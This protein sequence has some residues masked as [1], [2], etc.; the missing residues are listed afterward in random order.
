MHNIQSSL[1]YNRSMIK[2]ILYYAISLVGFLFVAGARVAQAVSLPDFSNTSDLPAF[3]SSVYSFAL[4]VVGIAVFIRILY[5][6]FLMLTAAG[7]S[8]KWGD[9]KTKMQNA[10]VGT[11]LLF[12]AY[13]I[14]YV[15]N[16]DLV[17]NT[18]NFSIPSSTYTAPATESVKTNTTGGPVAISGRVLA[19][20]GVTSFY[21]LPI[22]RAQ[23][24]IYSFTIKV[25][26][27]NGDTCRQTYN[28]EV[29]PL[30][31]TINVDFYAEHSAAGKYSAAL[32]N[33]VNAQEE[34]G[35]GIIQIIQGGGCVINT[36][37]LPDAI[38][39]TPYYAEIFVAGEA[40]FVYE[41]EDGVL[42]GG[43]SI[44]AAFDMPILTI[45]NLTA[46][47]TPI[48]AFKVGD[49][50]R[51][52]LTG[53]KPNSDV[54]F[55]WFKD[56]SG[57]SY[58]GITPNSEGWSKYGVTDGDGNWANQAA[59]TSN[60]I[61][62]WQEYAMVNGT[63]SRVIEFQILAP[64]V[65]IIVSTPAPITGAPVY[66]GGGYGGGGGGGG[67]CQVE[68]FCENETTGA[69]TAPLSDAAAQQQ[70]ID[71]GSSDRCPGGRRV[72]TCTYSEESSQRSE[73]DANQFDTRNCY[74]EL[75]ER[76]NE[77]GTIDT[78]GLTY[79]KDGS[80]P[81]NVS[82]GDLYIVDQM[83]GSTA[84]GSFNVQCRYDNQAAA[85]GCGNSMSG[86]RCL[87][88]GAGN[89]KWC[90]TSPKNPPAATPAPTRDTGGARSRSR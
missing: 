75:N 30:T 36:K 89:T 52:D 1:G 67:G 9:A 5:A 73:C 64:E 60:E 6:G 38:E 42:P 68:D 18:F 33:A 15:I 57:W 20:G 24:G 85:I 83:S 74:D 23:E 40:P 81:A 82:A 4:T 88:G 16:P 53:A 11:I 79:S 41:I 45:K 7:N 77:D 22:A 39:G 17:K 47:R 8:S 50:F 58:P 35:S 63:V 26:D 21:G 28:I 32:L 13:L 65:K 55:R 56:G 51:L 34:S 29:V 19:S 37:I 31:A 43:L 70:S 14:L 90:N 27:R 48:Y 87:P 80:P 12:A 69:K 71:I 61:G 46:Q 44:V 10:I 59:F 76:K 72:T 25:T 3:I 54:Y 66:S 49:T 2:R 86:E 62:T 78:A 84:L